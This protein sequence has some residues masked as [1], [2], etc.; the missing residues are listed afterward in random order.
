MNPLLGREFTWKIKPYFLNISCESPA[1]QKIHMEHQ[2][3]FSLKDKSKKIK[4]HLLQF[5]FGA[6]KVKIKCGNYCLISYE[7]K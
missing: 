6:L 3:L 5:F 4:C 7:V 2:A 1:R